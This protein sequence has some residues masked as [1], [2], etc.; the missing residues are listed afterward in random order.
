MQSGSYDDN[1]VLERVVGSATFQRGRAYARTGAVLSCRWSAADQQ[2]FG[3]VA[4]SGGTPYTTLV[5]VARDG[6]GRLTKFSSSCTCPVHLD[7]KHGVALFLAAETPSAE[8]VAASAV[9]VTPQWERTLRNLLRDD[10]DDREQ[11]EIG[12]QFEVI[13][14]SRSYRTGLA[15]P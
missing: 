9:V 14:A 7:C 4:G 8:P 11:P 13:S 2:L 6:S 12:L 15:S 5:R 1:A 3:E 10:Q